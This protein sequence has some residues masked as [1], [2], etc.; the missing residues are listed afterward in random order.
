MTVCS[1]AQNLYE[2]DCTYIQITY[3]ALA[4]GKKSLHFVCT[5][6][7]HTD[8]FEMWCTNIYH[9]H[10][11][12]HIEHASLVCPEKSFPVNSECMSTLAIFVHEFQS[13]YFLSILCSSSYGRCFMFVIQHSKVIRWLDLI[14]ISKRC[15]IHN[16]FQQHHQTTWNQPFNQSTK[17]KCGSLLQFEI[18]I[19]EIQV[20]WAFYTFFVIQ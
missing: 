12:A 9:L 1:I 18:R 6:W 4:F 11:K 13:L 2:N 17:T 3:C 16:P 19:V 7:L 8:V 10:W 14:T 20:H 15:W 5:L